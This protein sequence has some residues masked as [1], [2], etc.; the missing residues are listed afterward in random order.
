MTEF[1]LSR[2][3]RAIR[4]VTTVYRKG[5]M[6]EQHRTAEV[7][8]IQVTE[9]FGYRHTDEADAGETLVDLVF[10]NVGVKPEAAERAEEFMAYLQA[11]HSP[12]LAD[13]PSYI[14]TGGELGDQET[15]LRLFAILSVLGFVTIMTPAGLG[16]EGDEIR[17]MAGNGLLYALPGKGFADA[18]R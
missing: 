12:T 6:I 18:V 14:H 2:F 15:A 11:W 7:G 1:D 17:T 5:E 16:F 9:V 4:D 8:G 13:G 3:V 10:V